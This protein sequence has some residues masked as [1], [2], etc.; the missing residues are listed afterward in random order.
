MRPSA[1]SGPAVPAASRISVP[2]DPDGVVRHDQPVT[3]SIR[4]AV[5][6]DHPAVQ[7]LAGELTAGVAPWRP[8]AGVAAAAESWV[9]DACRAAEDDDHVLLVACSAGGEVVGFAGAT[10]R[11]HFS[12]EREAYLGELVVAPS[13]RG[14]GIAGRLVAAVEAWALGQGLHRVT[15]DT[16]AANTAARALYAQLGYAEEQVQLTRALG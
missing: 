12:G 2:V 9:A 15:L 14:G 10:A 13:A 6:S 3:V 16:G 11:R 1:G 7:A 4:A 5:P 8:A